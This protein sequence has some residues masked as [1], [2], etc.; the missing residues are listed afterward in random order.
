MAK[1]Q[2]APELLISA[3]FERSQPFLSVRGASFDAQRN[4]IELDIDGP[5]VPQCERVVAE[6]HQRSFHVKFKPAP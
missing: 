6:I 4:V 1:L 2:V 3:L 5:D